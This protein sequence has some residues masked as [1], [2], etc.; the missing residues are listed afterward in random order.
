MKFLG[1]SVILVLLSVYGQFAVADGHLQVT[2]QAEHQVC[3]D[4]AD[5]IIVETRCDG[6]EC[7]VPVHRQHEALYRNEL[8]R[9]CAKYSGSV[10]RFHCATPYADCRNGRCS[11]VKQDPLAEES[12]KTILTP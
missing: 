2:V 7:G 4:R 5:C 3:I 8:A 9:L 11:L 1:F 12:D 10:C 6:C